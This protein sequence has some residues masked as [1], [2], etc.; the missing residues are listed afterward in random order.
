MPYRA[1]VARLTVPGEPPLP[2]AVWYPTEMAETVTPVGIHSLAGAFGAAPASGRFP[3]L[4][5]SHGSLGSELGHHDWAETLA[6][7]GFVVAAPRHL[8][9]S[10]DRP[11]GQGSDVQLVGRPWQV[12]RTIDAMLADP[13]FAAAIDPARIGMIGFSA[14]GYTALVSLGARP[15]FGRWAV[16]CRLHPEDREFCPPA[17]GPRYTAM[18]RITRPGW[19]VPDEV[20]V[21]SAVVMAPTAFLF[22]RAGLARIDAPLRVY[23]AGDDRTARN[24]WNAD[25]L[26]DGLPEMPEQV[27]VPGGHYVFLAPATQVPAALR[28][29]FEDPPGGRPYRH[30]RPDRQG[31]GGVL[32]PGDAGGVEG[33]NG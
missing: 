18:P 6:R 24:A 1:G 25:R 21:R 28:P 29:L 3:L 5:L 15:D 32:P 23:R 4:L 22:D 16:H 17:L 2:A 7:H 33:G 10:F 26:I 12:T 30:P 31:V 20:R 13:K 11:E 27:T 8:G 19:A 9:D 14:G